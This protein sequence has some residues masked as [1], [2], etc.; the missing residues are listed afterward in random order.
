MIYNLIDTWGDLQFID[1]LSIDSKSR[2][3]FCS[4]KLDIERWLNEEA[5]S[6]AAS[7]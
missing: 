3:G 4:L 7:T 5:C 1:A 2:F 6:L